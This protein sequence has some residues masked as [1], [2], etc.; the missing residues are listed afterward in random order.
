MMLEQQISDA[1][2]RIHG[3]DDPWAE[4][5]LWIRERSALNESP[6]GDEGAFLTFVIYHVLLRE[7]W[8]GRESGQ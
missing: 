6:G 7:R 1:L 4:L 8:I 5:A 2:M 3:A